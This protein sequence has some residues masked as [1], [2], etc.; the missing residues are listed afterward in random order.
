MRNKRRIG[1]RIQ[2]RSSLR[3]AN[4]SRTVSILSGISIQAPS[5]Q[6]PVRSRKVVLPICPSWPPPLEAVQREGVRVS[7]VSTLRSSLPMM[8]DELRRQTDEFLDLADLP[9]EIARSPRRALSPRSNCEA[10]HLPFYGPDGVPALWRGSNCRSG[11]D[12]EYRFGADA[13]RRPETRPRPATALKR[14]QVLSAL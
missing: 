11:S 3:Q 13:N 4:R 12:L 7:V 6:S 9:P 5:S 14:T 10:Q 1:P 2:C 8:A